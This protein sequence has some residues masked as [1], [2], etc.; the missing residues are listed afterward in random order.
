MQYHCLIYFDPRQAVADTPEARA[1]LADIGPFSG[2]LKV[3]GHLA[4]SSR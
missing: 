4:P 2:R 3:S 1:V